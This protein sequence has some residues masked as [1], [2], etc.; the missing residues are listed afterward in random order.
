MS[1]DLR[2]LSILSLPR[3]VPSRSFHVP[4]GD[5]RGDSS[6]SR[7]VKPW[8]SCMGQASISRVGYGEESTSLL[9][10][11]GPGGTARLNIL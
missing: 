11:L 9:C 5:K 10:R 2:P 6:T 1:P 8:L 4:H 7:I 3:V